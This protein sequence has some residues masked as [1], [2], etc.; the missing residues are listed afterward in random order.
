MSYRV[1][2]AAFLL[3]CV[4][5]LGEVTPRDFYQAIRENDLAKIKSFLD[6]GVSVDLRDTRGNTPLMH[7]A[8][9]G[10]IEAMRL[11][12]KAGAD[13]NAKNGLD[14]T[15][16]VWSASNA[17]KAKLLIDAGAQVNVRTKMSRTPLM[18]AASYPGNT[19][20]VKLLL[21]KGADTTVTEVRGNTALVDAART[22]NTEAIRLLL[23]HKVDLDAGD[24]GGITALGHAAS[25][26]NIAAMKML[27]AKG[28][29]VNVALKRE[30]K[31]KNG[32]IA[33]SFQTPL[34]SA[35]AK[36]SIE[37]VRMLLDAGA[38]VKARDVRGMTPLMMAVASD[39]ADPAIV[40]LLL[41]KG[42]DTSVKTVDGETTLDWARKFG[43]PRIIAMLGGQI[44]ENKAVV[45]PAAASASNP[46]AAIERAMPLLTSSAKE[47]FRMSGCAGCH[48]QHVI[49]MAVPAAARKGIAVDESFGRD[50]VA[51]MKSDV[52]GSREALLQDIFISVDG[53]VFSMLG[54]GE[55][56]YPADEL[57]DAM[58]SAI[59]ARQTAE[60]NFLHFP[61]GRPPLEDGSFVSGALAVRTLQR[62]AIPARKAELDGR[63]AK[64]RHWFLSAKPNAAYERA[65]HVMGLQWSGADKAAVQRAVSELRKL[66]RADGGWAQLST[67]QSDAFGTSTALY[68]LAQAGVPAQDAAYQRGVRFLLSTQQPDGSWHVASRSPK[69]QPYFQSGFP[70]NHDQ[71]IS[72]AAT[73]WSVTALAEA[74]EPARQ[75]AGLR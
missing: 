64:A 11:L 9:V 68:A 60:G 74:V 36:G 19:A 72:A 8:S 38:D 17:E 54:M 57:T 35:A 58:V 1:C 12:M 55:Q 75:S 62:Y 30:L 26:S 4:C 66:Q 22:D 65:F 43:N 67:L 2:C 50:Q 37:S 32:L 34:M 51:I 47:Y 61:L 3:S 15:S 69:V 28:A 6:A 44:S 7:A 48:H 73:S 41:D 13:V 45:R 5:A 53:L 21:E 40:K 33:V 71:W 56:K 70:H 42:S 52:V 25:H 63:I 14:A 23:E 31:V 49:G 27:L 24:F 20:T 29:K 46:R 18:M 10:S 59:A 16:L 39:M